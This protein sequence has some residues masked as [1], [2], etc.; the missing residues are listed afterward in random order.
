M[1]PHPDDLH[2]LDIIQHLIHKPML[3]V[4]PAGAG[5][6]EVAD[7]LLVGRRRLAGVLCEKIEETLRLRFQAR[8]GELFCVTP[9][10]VG[11]DKR[12]PHQSSPFLHF[13]TGVFNPLII[14]ERIPGID[15]R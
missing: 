9:R 10:L 6:G 13:F 5:A 14:E 3:N 12:P 11:I 8:S 15:N 1:R 4:D 2:R 7:K